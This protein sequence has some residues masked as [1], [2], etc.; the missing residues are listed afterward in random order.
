MNKS[1]KMVLNS[2]LCIKPYFPY[3]FHLIYVLGF[4]SWQIKSATFVNFSKYRHFWAVVAY[5]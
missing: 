2:L 1:Y 4:Q 3:Y 5:K